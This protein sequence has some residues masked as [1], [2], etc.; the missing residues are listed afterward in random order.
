MIKRTVQ[1]AKR[2]LVWGMVALAVCMM[3]FTVIS[4]ATFDRHD[5]QLFGYK[6]YIV[7]SD[8]MAKTDFQAGDLIFVRQVDPATLQEGDIITFLSQDADSFGET[9]T[10]KIRRLTCDADGNPGF[11]TYGTT[12]DVD[13]ATVVTCPYILGKYRARVPY[14]GAFFQFLKTT[15]G[16]FI[17]IFLPFMALVVYEG[18]QLVR[19]L[20]RHQAERMAQMQA[21]KDDMQQQLQALQAQLAQQSGQQ[22]QTAGR[23]A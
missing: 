19:Q 13:D 15:T 8:S 14:I 23:S 2:I 16:Y 3:L 21:E 22:E 6:A 11:I 12:T 4:A 1:I 20:R 18:V 17:C 7:R 5:R 9:V 10:H